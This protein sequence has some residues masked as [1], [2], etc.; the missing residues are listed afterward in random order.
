MIQ[1]SQTTM[2]RLWVKLQRLLKI[3]KTKGIIAAL[4]EIEA[5]IA[6][7]AEIEDVNKK[8]EIT[9]CYFSQVNQLY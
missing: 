6:S 2:I 4:N 8:N 9:S 7:T 1:C 5:V 3:K